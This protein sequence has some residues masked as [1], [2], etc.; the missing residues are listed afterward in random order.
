MCGN[1]RLAA[2]RFGNAF[3]WTKV[4]VGFEWDVECWSEA[5]SNGG[6]SGAG[7]ALRTGW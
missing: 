7:Y 2:W 5:V 1:E 3:G 6:F 4:V